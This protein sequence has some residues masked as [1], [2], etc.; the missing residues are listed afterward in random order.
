MDLTSEVLLPSPPSLAD[1]C[2]SGTLCGGGIVLGPVAL[3]AVLGGGVAEL[4]PLPL[5]PTALGPHCEHLG[6]HTH[7]LP[8]R[9]HAEGQL[10]T[11][12]DMCI[13]VYSVWAEAETG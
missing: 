12:G 3:G 8:N 5:A 4:T 7:P 1:F 10:G 6:E 2:F 11:S 13:Q 9:W